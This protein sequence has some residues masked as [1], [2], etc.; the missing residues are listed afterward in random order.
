MGKR[1]KD[2]VKGNRMLLLILG[3][4]SISLSNGFYLGAQA[5][6]R[7]RNFADEGVASLGIQCRS[8]FQDLSY[9][10]IEPIHFMFEVAARVLVAV[11]M[12]KDHR[13]LIC[14]RRT[15]DRE[16]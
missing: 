5:E 11:V 3:D 4:T 1:A 8:H 7:V 16:F 10:E 2:Q 15:D 9:E 12:L 6:H 14:E 13:N